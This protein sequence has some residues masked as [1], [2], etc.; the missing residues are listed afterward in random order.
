MV[1]HSHWGFDVIREQEFDIIKGENFVF[2]NNTLNEYM[3]NAK[4][5]EN[6]KKWL[7]FWSNFFNL[8]TRWLGGKL[9]SLPSLLRVYRVY[10]EST[11]KRVYSRVNSQRTSGLVN[12]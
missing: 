3:L 6:N 11:K 10:L 9:E 2:E 1:D 8:L 7:T 5:I 12:S 4:H